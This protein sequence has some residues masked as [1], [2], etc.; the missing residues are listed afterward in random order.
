[1]VQVEPKY[2]LYPYQQQVLHDLLAILAPD[3]NRV[4][5]AGPRVIAHLPTG[6]GKTRLA[7]HVACHTLNLSTSVGKMIIWLASTEELCQ[8][9]SDD[10]GQ[11]WSHLGNRT[12]DI[13]EFWG[14]RS[15]DLG[16]IRSGFLVAGLPK[17][18]AIA[19]NDHSALSSLANAAGL[20]IFDEAHQ[21][22]A[23]TY[24][25]ITE[26][27]VTYQP[28]LLGL[29]A[30]TGSYRR[31][32]RR[33]PRVSRIVPFQQSDNQRQRTLQPGRLPDNAGVSGRPGIHPHR[34][35]IR[36][37]NPRPHRHTRLFAR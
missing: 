25:F 17:L 37:A 16:K 9:A 15:T 2:G 13:H 6:A 12:V 21:A 14:N 22:I 34:G 27:L 18:W 1:M 31:Y 11:A 4:V 19:K 20:V 28:P 10:L 29:T 26:Q 3:H 8:Q 5:P 32:Q 30:T 24:R 23:R 33:R 7:C 35:P 36:T